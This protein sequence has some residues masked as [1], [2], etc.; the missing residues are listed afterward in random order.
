MLPALAEPLTRF[1]IFPEIFSTTL[2]VLTNVQQP[3]SQLVQQ[4][5]QS[6]QQ[7]QQQQHRK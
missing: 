7:Q 3:S 4:Q 5:E 1:Q 6:Q 2:P